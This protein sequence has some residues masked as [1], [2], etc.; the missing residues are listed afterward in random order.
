MWHLLVTVSDMLD[1]S[2]QAWLRKIRKT[3][4]N[5]IRPRHNVNFVVL[6][7]YEGHGIVSKVMAGLHLIIKVLN[8]DV[9]SKETLADYFYSV[10]I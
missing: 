3:V 10:N 2:G 1:V 6:V 4:L 7:S 5:K 8:M 9:D